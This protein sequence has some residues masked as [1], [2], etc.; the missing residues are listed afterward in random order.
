MDSVFQIIA[1]LSIF[2][3]ALIFGNGYDSRPR[4]DGH[5]IVYKRKLKR[6]MLAGVSLCLAGA[7]YLIK[8]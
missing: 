7:V 1:A 5:G 2:L 3:G 4:L 8:Y 6:L